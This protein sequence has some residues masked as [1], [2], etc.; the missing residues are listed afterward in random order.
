MFRRLYSGVLGRHF[1][2]LQIDK[3][4]YISCPTIPGEITEIQSTG[5]II[6]VPL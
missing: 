3:R 6:Q 5:E 4:S 1:D 2:I